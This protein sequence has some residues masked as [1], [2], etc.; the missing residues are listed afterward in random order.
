MSYID[1]ILDTIAQLPP[2]SAYSVAV[3]HSRWCP[4]LKLSAPRECICDA[5]IEVMPLKEDRYHCPKNEDIRPS[6]RNGTHSTDYYD[7]AACHWC[8]AKGGC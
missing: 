4:M 8:G 2:G 6:Y 1:R 3:K 7:G 5:E